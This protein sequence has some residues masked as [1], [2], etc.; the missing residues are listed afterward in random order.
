ML[1]VRKIQG[2]KTRTGEGLISTQRDGTDPGTLSIPFGGQLVAVPPSCHPLCPLPDPPRAVSVSTFLENR[3]GHGAIVLCTAQS[4]PPSWLALHHH[5]HLVAT[6]LSPAVTPGVRA[7]PS[8][9]A[10]RV[11]L[12]ALGTGAG[13]RYVCVATNALG[14]ATASADFD[15]RSEWGRTPWKS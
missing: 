2:G 4:H 15:V 10:L 9:N 13:G 12:V 8:H 3:D 1:Q 6:S 11:E 14:N 7:I 5:G